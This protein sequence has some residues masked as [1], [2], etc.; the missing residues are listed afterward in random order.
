MVTEGKEG[1]QVQKNAYG[2]KTIA[3]F[4]S[5]GDAQGMNSAVRAVVR[6]GIYVGCKV[7]LINE[8]YQ[9]MVD[10]GDHIKLAEWK[11]VSNIIQRGGTV[12]G[13]ARCKDFQTREGR[14]KAA[15][16]LLQLGITN[17]V[18]IGGDGSLTG[19]NLFRQEWSSILDELVEAGKLS[20]RDAVM[21]SHLNIVGLVGSI[22]NDFCGTDMT[23]GTDSALHRIVEAIDN[24]VTTASSHQRCFIMEVMGRHCGYLALVAALA[25][26]ADWVLIPEWP[27][28]KGW[29]DT[30]CAKLSQERTMGQRLNIIIIAEGAIDSDGK[31]ITPDYVK[32]LVSTRLNYDTRVTILGHVQRGGS[33]SAFDRILSCRMGAEAVL[34][35]MEATCS[36]PACVISLDGN[37]AARVP[38]L[39]C[40]ARTKAVQQAMDAKNF[41]RAVQLRGRSFINNLETYISLSKLKPPHHQ[42]IA[43]DASNYNLGVM[44]VGAP[45]CGMNAAARAFVRI[46]RTHG[47]NV[48]GIHYGFDGLVNDDVVPLLWTEVNGWAGAGGARLKTTRS[49]PSEEGIEKVASKFKK[50]NIHALLII[51]GFEAFHSLLELYEAREQFKEFCI[52]ITVIPA[53]IS[54]NIPGSDFSLGA[55]TSLNVIADICDR[56]KQSAAGT[57][58]RVYVIETMGGYCGYLATM[59]GLA[60]G[61]DAAYI[62]EEKFGIKDLQADVAHMAAKIQDG[63]KRG[64]ILLNESASKNYTGDFI[65]K[66][67]SEEGKGIFICRFNS[68]G[69]MQ[70]GGSPSPFD[71]NFGTKMASKC[72]IKLIEQLEANKQADGSVFTNNPDTA[73]LLGLIKQKSSFTPIK[74][75]KEHADFEHRVPKANWWLK[76]RPLLRILAKHESTYQ[77]EVLE[78]REH[79]VIIEEEQLIA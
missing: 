46:A 6:M 61:A 54:N 26:E 72:A 4:T 68:L 60:G 42:V 35:L 37:Q 47:Y 11:T 18:C 69:H 2:G 43:P 24:I 28:E 78:K 59:S 27:P 1:H 21:Y 52:P 16:N 39:E 41:E 31:P 34:A 9:G 19:A 51:G 7:Y 22:D 45:S 63:V 70:E 71:R 17:L 55:D 15:F 79:D 23:I 58:N 50:F 44:Y 75:L 3:V 77:A 66:L 20:D 10:G 67:Y 14:V 36:T 76:L 74:D 65:H 29:E 57:K 13:S 38:L 8:G 5:G 73:T 56:I 12:I 32:D 30:L 25:T 33:P 64:L 40:V 48:L 62:Y 49:R 53:T